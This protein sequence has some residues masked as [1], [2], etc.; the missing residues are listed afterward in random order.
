MSIADL[1][2]RHPALKYT[3][4]SNM[5]AS[6]L[7]KAG[8]VLDDLL[9]VRGKKL[10]HV[11]GYDPNA[12]N[13]E[14]HTGRALDFMVH[15]DR[16]AGD[17]IA[18]YV[19]KHGSRLG[20]VHVIW[21]QR[22]YRGPYSTSTNP[23]GVWQGMADRG[24][25]T[26]NHM[27]HPHVWL[28]DTAYK[29]LAAPTVLTIQL[30]RGATDAT[31]GGQ[32]SLLQKRLTAHGVKTN[33]DGSFG[34]ATETNVMTFQSNKK[35]VVDG[36]VGPATR[37]ALNA[38]PGPAEHPLKQYSTL[39]LKRG[40]KGPAVAALQGALG[41]IAVD[42]S[43]G[44]ATEQAVRNYQ[45]KKQ[46]VVSGIVTP[47]M[48]QALM[49]LPYIEFVPTPKPEP[50]PDPKPKP[51]PTPEPK[52]EPKPTGPPSAPPSPELIELADSIWRHTYVS[53]GGEYNPVLQELADIKTLLLKM[54][55]E[56]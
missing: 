54:Q 12:G 46:I 50:T 14:H 37:A 3:G 44:P 24:N 56:S 25:P 9:R 18:N 30:T 48:W 16:A 43:F 49:G 53:R 42:S 34:P 2:S 6:A 36:K 5:R 32:V 13:K 33:V 38:T 1:T 40:D 29:P 7:Y 39:T 55:K 11:W 20:L 31:T 4:T 47:N 10:T 45:T 17:H 51:E 22:I 26:Q 35:L 19:I 23:K 52:P 15:S 21:R 8:E 41:G 28:A 27:D